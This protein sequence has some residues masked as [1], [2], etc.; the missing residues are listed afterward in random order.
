MISQ[1]CIVLRVYQ[2][3]QGGMSRGFSRVPD[4]ISKLRTFFKIS[5]YLYRR[6]GCGGAGGMLTKQGVGEQISILC[7]R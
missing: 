5:K 3:A 7:V 2:I 6:S 4:V 1:S